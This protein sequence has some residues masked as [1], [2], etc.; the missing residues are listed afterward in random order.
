MLTSVILSLPLWRNKTA[1]LTCLPVHE[2]GWGNG[3]TGSWARQD[4]ELRTKERKKEVGSSCAEAEIWTSLSDFGVVVGFF[5]LLPSSVNGSK[6][7]WS[8]CSALPGTFVPQDT[9]WARGLPV[10]SEVPAAV[11]STVPK[12]D[13]SAQVAGDVEGLRGWGDTELESPTRRSWWAGP[14]W[15]WFPVPQR[16]VCTVNLS[17]CTGEFTVGT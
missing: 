13:T 4:L 6:G 3:A 9:A 17:L 2:Q 14:A 7:G 11:T 16:A 12:G 15:L 10:G 8:L 5:G 1:E